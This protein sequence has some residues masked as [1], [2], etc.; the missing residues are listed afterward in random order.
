MKIRC[1]T[2]II[3]RET[4]CTKAVLVERLMSNNNKIK[5]K[6]KIV[7]KFWKISHLGAFGT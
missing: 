6:N 5:S 1:T 7:T 4:Q 3:G 2:G